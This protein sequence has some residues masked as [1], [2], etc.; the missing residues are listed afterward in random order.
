MSTQIPND[1]NQIL[2]TLVAIFTGNEGESIDFSN[3]EKWQ[4]DV[5]DD[6]VVDM[7]KK[8]YNLSELEFEFATDEDAYAIAIDIVE[9]VKGNTVC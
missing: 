5:S 7:R 4:Q 6:G 2:E 9:T 3:I 1:I 8:I